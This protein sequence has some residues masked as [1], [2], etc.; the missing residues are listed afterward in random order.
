MK[1]LAIDDNHD[2]LLTLGALLKIF[3]PE[4]SLI[5]S[6][7]AQDG[8]RRARM[9]GP[10]AILLDI[11]MP[12]MDGFEATR[13][14]KSIPSTQHIPV[15]LVTAH[16]SD[17]ACRV[18]GLEC[19][20]D[21]FL[22]KPI[23][24]AELVA[25]IKAM[26]RIKRSED[27]LRRERDSLEALV[28]R[29]TGELLL[30]N[31]ELKENLERLAQSEARY[32]RAVRGTSDG[33]WD[34][35]L[36]SGDFYYS[37]RWKELLGFA[38]DELFNEADT[39]F[40]RLH[41]DE[42]ARVQDA[43]DAHFSGRSSFDLELRLRTREEV[44]LK[45]RC[46]GQ[47]EWNTEG[48]A[49]R[50]SGAITD[51]TE[52]QQMEEQL[53]QSQKMEAVGQLAGGVAHDFN[54]VLTVIAGYANILKMDLPDDS[55]HLELVEQIAVA[56]ERAAQLTRGLLAFSRKQAMAP[57]QTDVGEIVR[58]VEQFLVR[59]IGEDIQLKTEL[60]PE[61][62]PVFVDLGQIEQVLINLAANARDAMPR[63]GTFTIATGLQEAG[64][65]GAQAVIIVSDTGKGMD[66]ETRNRIFEP[67][68]TTKEVGKGT[69]LGMAIVY[70]II[71]QHKGS[72]RVSSTP[73]YGTTFTIELPLL[74]VE[75][76]LGQDQV[77]PFE[78]PSGTET[79]LVAEDDPSV[80]NLVEMVLTKHGYQVILA[81]DG[82]E[83]VERFALH[84]NGIGLVL[85]DI[86]MPRKNG[87]DAFDE[88]RKVRP[89]AKVLFTSGYTADFIQSRGMQEGVEL[90][91]KPVQPSELLRRVREVLER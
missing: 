30:A 70:G 85:M 12:G 90:I 73:G 48:E 27:A 32:S 31:R 41:P 28:A 38:D 21:A 87:I 66:E 2:N 65:G 44:Y 82:Q 13:R 59:V 49:V 20:A 63:G 24:E 25:Q 62:L 6:Q 7:S 80:R 50:L 5:T 4:A 43:L 16:R 3:L 86:I 69:G 1:L 54:N 26:V 83:V 40:S 78:P 36:K 57:Q 19:G 29:R 67:F 9:E 56:S 89:D 15:I 81:D 34:W 8:I 55:Q 77:A 35:D 11:Q 75:T 72:I 71:Q 14:L 46:R 22:S 45:V 23:D 42:V 51:I 88:I 33:L 58:R 60:L 53:R 79:I 61:R 10:D 91:M 39:F 17:S 84:Q 74:T 37:P 76:S 18:K 52:R 68:F 47:A 64:A